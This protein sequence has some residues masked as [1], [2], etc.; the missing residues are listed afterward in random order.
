MNVFQVDAGSLS[1]VTARTHLR[2]TDL[3][4][5]VVD[6]TDDITT[7]SAP[8]WWQAAPAV[9]TAP[10]TGG[11]RPRCN[12]RPV[13]RRDPFAPSRPNVIREVAVI[14]LEPYP[15]NPA[16]G[17]TA[18][19]NGATYHV[20]RRGHMWTIRSPDGG[21]TRVPTLDAAREYL[22]TLAGRDG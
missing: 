5:A 15:S 20:I 3:A 1:P 6:G 21:H 9:V 7:P 2:L 17:Y 18:Q 8:T 14:Q 22:S 13:H 16:D 11:I 4:R 10:L 19:V 12:A